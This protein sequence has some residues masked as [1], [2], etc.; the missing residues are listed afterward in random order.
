MSRCARCRRRWAAHQNDARAT[1]MRS[2]YCPPVEARVRLSVRD[3]LNLHEQVRRVPDGQV[4]PPR[5]VSHL[6][7]GWI[8]PD[9]TGLVCVGT[10][11]VAARGICPRHRSRDN[12]QCRRH[13]GRRGQ[14]LL[15]Q[16]SSPTVDCVNNLA[17]WP[18][19][20]SRYPPSAFAPAGIAYRRE[21]VQSLRARSRY[22]VGRHDLRGLDQPFAVAVDLDLAVG[23][24][25]HGHGCGLKR[26]WPPRPEGH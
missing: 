4:V 26:G 3:L 13:E 19:S 16:S 11:A 10:T 14:P 24:L 20:V 12:G 6:R 7:V 18:I 23:L 8:N 21:P 15:A 25:E 9:G 1:P 17:A 22:S 5:H 2:R